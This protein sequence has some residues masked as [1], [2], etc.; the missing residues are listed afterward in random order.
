MS[1]VMNTT[2]A[3]SATRSAVPET[4]TLD[5]TCVISLETRAAWTGGP[6]QTVQ[7]VRAEVTHRLRTV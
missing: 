4:T 1:A 6:D 7:E 2:T 3:A 5:T